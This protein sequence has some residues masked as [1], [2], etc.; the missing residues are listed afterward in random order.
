MPHWQPL[1]FSEEGQVSIDFPR[2][3]VG[4]PLCK[5]GALHGYEVVDVVTIAVSAQGGPEHVVRLEQLCGMEKGWRQRSVALAL[6]PLLPDREEVLSVRLTGV[7][8]PVDAIEA[9]GKYRGQRE[10]G[11]R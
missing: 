5:L 7:Q 11:I 3:N 9:G 6:G 4:V 1:A 2:T 8:I 10:V